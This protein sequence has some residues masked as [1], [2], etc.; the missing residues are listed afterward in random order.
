MERR[1][2]ESTT[3]FVVQHAEHETLIKW[4]LIR[5]RLEHMNSKADQPRTNEL[6]SDKP[7]KP[8]LRHKTGPEET[9]EEDGTRKQKRKARRKKSKETMQKGDRKTKDKTKESKPKRRTNRT[10][11]TDRAGIPAGQ[12]LYVP[13][14][15]CVPENFRRW[16]AFSTG[17]ASSEVCTFDLIQRVRY[18]KFRYY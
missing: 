15:V 11:E 4:D 12:L 8:P 9:R 13:T 6:S 18:T 5:S 1:C 16:A 14:I 3:E 7:Q 2:T 10:E 17:G